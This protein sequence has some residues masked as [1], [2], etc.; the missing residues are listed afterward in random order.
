MPTITNTIVV[1][2]ELLETL[3]RIIVTL[4][5]A[6]CSCHQPITVIGVSPVVVSDLVA[7][8]YII[9][10]A[11]ADTTGINDTIVETITVSRNDASSINSTE[12]NTIHKAVTP[13]NEL[14]SESMQLAITM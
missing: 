10:M 3:R 2:C 12:T 6:D 9:E 4:T 7:G 1:S 13:T 14:S 5:Y 8:Q 11:I